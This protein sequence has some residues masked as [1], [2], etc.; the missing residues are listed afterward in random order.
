M[1]S[2]PQTLRPVVVPVTEL[3]VALAAITTEGPLGM[4]VTK[5]VLVMT[6]APS[7]TMAVPLPA[8]GAE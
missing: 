1:G 7:W 4:V 5:A 8:A 3:D 2:V 6:P